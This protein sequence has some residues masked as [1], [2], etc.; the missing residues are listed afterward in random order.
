MLREHRAVFWMDA[1]IR[2][3]SDNL[4]QLVSRA[5][6][7]SGILTYDNAGCS[8][9]SATH[10]GMYRYL[11]VRKAAAVNATMRGAS[12]VYIR[13][14]RHVYESV[15]RWWVL[16]ALVKDCM[17]PTTDLYCR[18]RGRDQYASCHRYD[19]S[20]LNILLVNSFPY[21][22][23]IYFNS[24]V[25]LG[26]LTVERGSRGKNKLFVCP[27]PGGNLTRASSQIF[28]APDSKF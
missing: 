9:F 12:A 27:A 10:M 20:A 18:F 13:R 14:T 25:K 24:A 28:F 5:V 2:F 11:P 23:V 22:D 3:H 1:S 21:D 16:C 15:V 6:S 7:T 19:Q 8:C 17:A 26:L 4:M